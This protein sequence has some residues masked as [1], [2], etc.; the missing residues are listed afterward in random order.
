MAV[1]TRRWA[2]VTKRWHWDRPPGG[3]L[4]A[5]FFLSVALSILLAT[6]PL[7]IGA[8]LAAAVLLLVFGLLEPRVLLAALIFAVPFSRLAK[9]DL[10]H[11]SVSAADLLVALV[12]ARWLIEGLASRRLVVWFGPSLVGATLFFAS[13]LLS[14]LFAEDF[15][16]SLAELI[17]LAEM[18]VVA[19][20]ATTHLD[21]RATAVFVMQALVLAGAAES[22]VAIFQTVTASG[23]ASFAL[24]SFVRAY[25]DF[26]QPNVLG[27]YL[28]LTLPFGLILCTQRSRS[29]PVM[30]IATGLI[31]LALGATLSRGA[32][33]GALVSLGFIAWLWS[34]QTRR[35]L[36]VA[37][38]ALALFGG[39]A[40]SG[41]APAAISD[42][43][44]VLTENFV[45]FDART[46]DVTPINFSLIERMAHWQAGWAMGMDHP[47]VGVGP[48]NFEEM[49]SHY[50]LPGWPLALGHA[51]NIYINTFAEQGA[52]GLLSLLLFLGVVFRRALDFLSLDQSESDTARLSLLA[53]FGALVAFSVH[54][55][56]DNM[57]VHGI[58]IELGLLLGLVEAG[59]VMASR[60]L[61]LA[62][63]D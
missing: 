46:V 31:A 8:G 42:R 7:V 60:E 19:L 57:F 49:Y 24:G 32:W 5:A 28:A 39:L 21:D 18:I 12:A 53:A 54:N 48:G 44:T 6:P 63:R 41:L 45:V 43:L 62:N 52:I 47:I 26:D 36:M 33:L 14:S 61:E 25:G 13:A 50:F 3:V 20:Y 56:F 34:Q 1:V 58:G 22:L 35:A 59:R 9:V 17:K 51:H 29:R 23:P 2:V 4:A 27:G 16:A 37:V 10:G 30:A 55:V 38:A 11:F 15:Q 40:M